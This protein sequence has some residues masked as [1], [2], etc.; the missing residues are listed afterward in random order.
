MMAEIKHPIVVL[1][2]YV[3]EVIQKL[4]YKDKERGNDTEMRK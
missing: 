3:K 1:K 2:D 4:E